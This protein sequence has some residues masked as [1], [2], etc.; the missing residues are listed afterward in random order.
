MALLDIEHLSV[1]YPVRRGWLGRR[2]WVHAV[3]DVSFAIGAGETV[4]L[5]GESGCGK[6]SLARALLGLET[7]CAGRIRFADADVTAARGPL[8]RRLLRGVQMVFQDPYGSLN[9]RRRIGS[10]L[11]EVLAVHSRLR[12][13]ARRERAVELLGLVGLEA[14]HL[15]RWPHQ[16]S[17]GQRQRVG[18]ARALAVEPRLLLADEPVSALDVSVQAQIINLLADLQEKLGLAYLFVAHDLAVVEHVRQR[19]LVM[20]LG[21]I[22][23]AAPT[24][25]LFQTPAHPYTRALLAALPRLDAARR[26]VPAA[27]PG[28]LPSPL[29]PPPG[30]AFHPRCPLAQDIC[31]RV[32]PELEPLAADRPGHFAACHLCRG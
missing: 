19:V 18:I 22:V 30:C 8:R 23:E 17:G 20:Y 16:L 3:D 4:G 25:A 14:E 9:P 7:A 6:S 21:R 5:V 31:R 32:R 27:P 26:H 2:A 12:G 28:D 1:R 29:A 13:A 15:G 24:A 11:E 10:M